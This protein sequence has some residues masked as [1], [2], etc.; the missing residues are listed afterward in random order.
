MGLAVTV[1][2]SVTACENQDVSYDDFEYQTVY[3]ANQY[4][5]RTLELGEDDFVDVSLDNEHKVKIV[6]TLGGTV[7][8]PKDRVVHFEVVNDFCDG[9][10]FFADDETEIVAMPTDYYSLSSDQIVIPSG[11]HSGGVEVSLTDKFFEDSLTLSRHYVIPLLLTSVESGDSILS[12]YTTLP[13]ANRF[14]ESDWIT[15]PK[16]YM[17]YAVK[18]VNPWHGV[19]LRHGV[20]V[21]TMGGTTQTV[22][23]HE[24]YVEDDELVD[25]STLGLKE[26]LVELTTQDQ[27]GVNI[28][29][30]LKLTFDDD[31]NCTL[32]SDAAYDYEVE[33]TGRFVIDGE[34]NSFGGKDRNALYLNYSVVFKQYN[35]MKYETTDTLVVQTR[36]VIPEYFSVIVQ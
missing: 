2:V 33:G 4:P 34:K 11:E 8:N 32:S 24:Q 19:Y 1:M 35:N 25:I 13:D 18:Y 12:G 20:D 9:T 7:S 5:V 21:V 28:P 6:A 17:L 10:I 3:F 31:N 15:E 29:Y 36:N 23:R 22:A 30:N 16:D 14:E 26:A 27:S